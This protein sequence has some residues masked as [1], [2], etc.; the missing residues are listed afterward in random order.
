[1]TKAAHNKIEVD[2]E[3]LRY[4]YEHVGLTAREAA[5]TLEVGIGTIYNRL[6]VLGITKSNSESHMGQ[7]PW[8]YKGRYKDSQGYILVHVPLDDKF[9]CMGSQ[10]NSSSGVYIRE[11]RLFV[12][13][14]MDRP[15]KE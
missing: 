7:K 13:R 11:H 3:M 14:F 4:L 6:R 9:A 5:A 10:L 12:A 1:M 15:G 2:M 8:N